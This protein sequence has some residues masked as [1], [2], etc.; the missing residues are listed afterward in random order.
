MR[1]TRPVRARLSL[2]YPGFGQEQVGTDAP[3]HAAEP[4]GPRKG[5][6]SGGRKGAAANAHPPASSLTTLLSPRGYPGIPLAER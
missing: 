6:W 5:T 4:E 1:A 3:R 2:G